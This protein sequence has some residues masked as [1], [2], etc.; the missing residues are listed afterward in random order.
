VLQSNKTG[1]VVT[2]A[3]TVV[4]K[5]GNR[6]LCAIRSAQDIV[7]NAS[8]SLFAGNKDCSPEMQSWSKLHRHAA[9]PLLPCELVVPAIT[10]GRGKEV[11]K[12]EK[13]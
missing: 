11:P 12:E 9:S 8:Q 4:R 5:Y 2:P 3:T 13:N 6:S 7:A 10:R 1:G